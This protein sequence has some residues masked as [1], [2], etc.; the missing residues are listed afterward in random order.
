MSRGPRK[1]SEARGFCPRALTRFSGGCRLRRGA[2]V[3]A[4]AWVAVVAA[5]LAPRVAA[6]QTL[7]PVIVEH[8]GKKAQAKFELRNDGLVP[9]NVVLEPKSFDV[10]I[11]GEVAYRPLDSSVHLK[12]SAMSLRIPAKQS[13]WV[14][15]EATADSYPA[16]F[17]IPCTFS[18]MPKH[19]G[20]NVTV[21]LPHTVYLVQDQPVRREDVKIHSAVYTASSAKVYLELENVSSRLGRISAAEVR[22]KDGR[23]AF[24]SFPLLPNRIRRVMIPWD[25]AGVPTTLRLTLQGFTIETPLGNASD[26]AGSADGK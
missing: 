10:S 6:A 14:F 16:W 17:V 8:H 1:D 11:D 15:Y 24:S 5:A 23:S 21:E 18:G 25:G 7:S 26:V 22:G 13:R 4:L 19:Q 9:L 3:V 2:A 20:L 12:L